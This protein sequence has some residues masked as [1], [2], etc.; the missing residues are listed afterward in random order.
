MVGVTEN[1][2]VFKARAV[3]RFMQAEGVCQREIYRRSVNI[4]SQNISSLKE[5]PV[6]GNKFKMAELL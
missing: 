1:Y 6:W 3:V 2:P 5:V 4:Y